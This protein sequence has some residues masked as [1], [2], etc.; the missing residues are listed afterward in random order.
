MREGS[1]SR[2][3][4][5]MGGSPQITA[6][7]GTKS[8]WFGRCPGTREQQAGPGCKTRGDRGLQ[9]KQEVRHSRTVTGRGW[10]GREGRSKQPAE[11][12]SPS[13]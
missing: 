4:A 8:P 12:G 1:S 11:C 3:A 7:P 10:Q 9:A 6:S 5:G 13:L 2:R